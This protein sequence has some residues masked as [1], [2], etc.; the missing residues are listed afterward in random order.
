MSP[1]GWSCVESQLNASLL[2]TAS[3]A[4]CSAINITWHLEGRRQPLTLFFPISCSDKEVQ[5]FQFLCSLQRSMSFHLRQGRKRGQKTCL[6]ISFTEKIRCRVPAE[7][8]CYWNMR[9]NAEKA[10]ILLPRIEL[11]KHQRPHKE[12]EKHKRKKSGLVCRMT[13]CAKR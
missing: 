2:C 4:R 11:H 10:G 7:A 1:Y 12:E 9:W 3:L 5:G 6:A 13:K 8:L